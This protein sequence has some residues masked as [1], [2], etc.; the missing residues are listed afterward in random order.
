MLNRYIIK[1]L[2]WCYAFSRGNIAIYEGAIGRYVWDGE[3]KEV[4]FTRYDTN[5][6]GGKGKLLGRTEL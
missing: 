5:Y 4:H 6:H 2:Q 3:T 1:K